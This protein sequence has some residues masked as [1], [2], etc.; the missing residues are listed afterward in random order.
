M[1]SKIG[2]DYDAE[3]IEMGVDPAIQARKANTLVTTG[4]TGD[5][6][7]FWS[8]RRSK[9]ESEICGGETFIDDFLRSHNAYIGWDLYA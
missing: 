8:Q 5:Q 4:E 3:L 2:F 6:F 7:V 9:T 1:P